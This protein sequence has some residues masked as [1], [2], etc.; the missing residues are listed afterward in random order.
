MLCSLAVLAEALHRIAFQHILLDDI[1]C[2][3]PELGRSDRVHAVSDENDCIEV[4][5]A[6]FLVRCVSGATLRGN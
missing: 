5:I 6:N 1:R 3:N 2:P 4:V